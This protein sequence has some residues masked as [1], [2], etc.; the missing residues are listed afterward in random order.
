MDPLAIVLVVVAVVLGAAAAWLWSSARSVRSRLVEA[1]RELAERF[2]RVDDLTERNH[3][4]ELRLAQ[5]TQA[6]EA[7]ASA[8]QAEIEKV[9]QIHAERLQALEREKEQ[10]ARQREQLKETFA[11]LATDAMKA[12]R[13]ELLKQAREHFAAREKEG[14]AELDER[15]KAVERMVKPIGETLKKTEERL[16]RLDEQVHGSKSASEALRQETARLVTA[17]REPHVRGRYGEIQLQRVAELAGMSEHCDFT[18]QSETTDAE[19]KALRPDMVV[20]LPERCEVVVDA[21]TNIFAYLEALEAETTEQAEAC[22][23]R[24]ARHVAEQAQKLA[25][26]GYWSRYDGSPEFVVMFVP[27]DQFVDAALARRPDLLESAASAGV[28]IASP[29]TLIGL[30]RAVEVGWR[31]YGLARNAEALLELGR[32]LHERAAVAFEHMGKLGGT[33][34]QAVDRYNKMVGSVD[35]RLMPTLRKFEDSGVKSGKA[36]T[37]A[38]RVTIVPRSLEAGEATQT[39]SV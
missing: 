29:T 20:H 22:L 35:T 14:E 23:D 3:A 30:L 33:L 25:R 18:T 2:R 17:L 34:R 28:I 11:T 36:L 4:L 24:F 6:A 5:E 16:L 39:D 8:H 13:D 7:R 1:E 19:G 10:L 27:G 32:E 26:K 9:E 37:D 12:S 15:R 38:A 31:G 21:K